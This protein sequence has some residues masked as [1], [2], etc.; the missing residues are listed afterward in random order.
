[1][2]FATFLLSICPLAYA[3]YTCPSSASFQC[4]QA[5]SG[6]TLSNYYSNY[7][8]LDASCPPRN[9]G[10]YKLPIV[11]RNLQASTGPNP[12]A[13]ALHTRIPHAAMASAAISHK[14]A[15]IPALVPFG[16]LAPAQAVRRGVLSMWILGWW[17]GYRIEL[18]GLGSDLISVLI[19]KSPFC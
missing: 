6:N 12:P 7:L 13:A 5:L 2:H 1:M 10:Q 19:A 4:C 16:I 3:S 14:V 17:N 11:T 8:P 15:P 18:A 9:L